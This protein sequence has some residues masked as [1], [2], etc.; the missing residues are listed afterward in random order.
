MFSAS[1]QYI[2][3]IYLSVLS[4][5][6]FSYLDNIPFRFFME[7]S[8]VFRELSTKEQKAIAEEIQRDL[9]A[10]SFSLAQEI[11]K[12]PGDFQDFTELVHPD[13]GCKINVSSKTLDQNLTSN[14]KSCSKVS[15]FGIFS[16]NNCLKNIC[17]LRCLNCE[18]FIKKCF[19]FPFTTCQSKDFMFQLHNY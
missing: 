13:C 7:K 12:W 4:Y 6:A 19:L 1:S 10:R 16:A 14:R 5:A 8:T 2:G 11:H 15:V 9:N 18:D 3:L 17:I